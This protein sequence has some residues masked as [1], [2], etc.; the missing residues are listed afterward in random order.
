MTVCSKG[1]NM[2]VQL[3]IDADTCVG[4]GEC[5]AEDPSAMELDDRGCARPLVVSLDAHRAARIC[6]ACPVGA[7]TPHPAA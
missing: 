3:V 7:I 1:A 5:V 4:Y 6:D 2:N